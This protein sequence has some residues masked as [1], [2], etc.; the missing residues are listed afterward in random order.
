VQASAEAAA[1]SAAVAEE[2]VR[3]AKTAAL[4]FCSSLLFH[5]FFKAEKRP[6]PDLLPI[7]WTEI[8]DSL[9]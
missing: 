1:R 6:A 9:Q 2:G 3:A 4:F 7:N 8:N 5:R